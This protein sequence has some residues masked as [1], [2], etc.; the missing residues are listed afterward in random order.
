MTIDIIGR[1]RLICYHFRRHVNHVIVG[2]FIK[3]SP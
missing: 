1:I 3:I 2:S